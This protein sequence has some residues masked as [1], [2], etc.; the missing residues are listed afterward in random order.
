MDD[1]QEK[2]GLAARTSEYLRRRTRQGL[3]IV[4]RTVGLE[5]G[6]RPTVAD[7]AAAAAAEALSAAEAAA[8]HAAAIQHV[9]A[10]QRA[11]AAE[12][13][14]AAAA[15]LASV[16]TDEDDEAT[17]M[18]A[19]AARLEA[20][21]A[22]IASLGGEI[23]LCSLDGLRPMRR[24]DVDE[25]DLDEMR[26]LR[27]AVIAEGVSLARGSSIE[28]NGE[29]NFIVIARNVRLRRVQIV[30]R[31]TGNLIYIGPNARLHN[32]VIKAVGDGNTIA[33]GRDVTVESGSFLCERVGR[34]LLIGDDCMLSN[35]VVVRTT[36]HHGIFVRSSGERLNPPA[37]V[38]I[39]AHVWLG[40]SCR[41]NKG[42]R[43][44]T[45]TVIGQNAIA[46]GEIE[47]HCIYAGIPARKLRDDIV[48]SR[49]ESLESVAKRFR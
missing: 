47:P 3:R 44:G 15:R 32:A 25:K 17:A 5:G 35:A 43:I 18:A 12:R 36:D 33:I 42:A 38:V 8:K 37:D 2:P 45:G 13:A 29:E 11:A 14:A 6:R 22:V 30:V 21:A 19:A 28:R 20:C 23:T 4:R 9:F 49:T 26:D 39:G 24:T 31:G 1:P 10:A 48:W 41:V 16:C 40:N 34:T 27:G 7:A 46:G